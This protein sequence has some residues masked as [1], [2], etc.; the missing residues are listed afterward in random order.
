M[1]LDSWKEWLLRQV[2]ATSHTAL[3]FVSWSSRNRTPRRSNA[4]PSKTIENQMMPLHTSP[5]SR[6]GNCAG[7]L[8]A[9]GTKHR[10][11]GDPTKL[12]SCNPYLHSHHSHANGT[13]KQKGMRIR[14]LFN[15]GKTMFHGGILLFNFQI[16]AGMCPRV[17]KSQTYT[18]GLFYL[19]QIKASVQW[20]S[21]NRPTI[22]RANIF[23]RDSPK[24]HLDPSLVGVRRLQKFNQCITPW[25]AVPTASSH[26]KFPAEQTSCGCIQVCSIPLCLDCCNWLYKICFHR[27]LSNLPANYCRPYLISSHKMKGHK[28]AAIQA[29]CIV[30]TD[31]IIASLNFQLWRR[32]IQLQLPNRQGKQAQFPLGRFNQRRSKT[33]SPHTLHCVSNEPSNST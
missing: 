16:L 33:P 5:I 8:H 25:V 27:R 12:I 32:G 26:R 9:I 14:V 13:I 11:R 4:S 22:V 2:A 15:H 21:N 29:T 19:L 6:A 24:R 18:N 23:Q 30:A 17:F 31:V 3:G 10:L 20:H 1:I 7:L 28:R